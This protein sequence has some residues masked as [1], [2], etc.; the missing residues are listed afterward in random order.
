MGEEKK[1]PGTGPSGAADREEGENGRVPIYLKLAY[2]IIVVWA[3]IYFL[4]Y[5]R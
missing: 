4:L 3:M 1:A 2:V 5:F